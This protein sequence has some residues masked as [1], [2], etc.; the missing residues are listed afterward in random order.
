MA[1]AFLL[2]VAVLVHA[3]RARGLLGPGVSPG[4]KLHR[5]RQVGEIAHATGRRQKRRFLGMTQAWRQS[6][7]LWHTQNRSQSS[8]VG[9]ELARFEIESAPFPEVLFGTSLRLGVPNP[10][11]SP[12]PVEY[13]QVWGPAFS[14]FLSRGGSTSGAKNPPIRGT[15]RVDCPFP[16]RELC[17]KRVGWTFTGKVFKA[18]HL[19][20]KTKR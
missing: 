16:I 1:R 11:G 5:G 2:L 8:P 15:P 9:H 7:R 12:S 17:S 14:G 20:E 18:S 6:L 4:G 3:A 10:A 19:G 13:L